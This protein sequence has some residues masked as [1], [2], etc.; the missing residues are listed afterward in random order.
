MA[1]HQDQNFLDETIN[2]EKQRRD[3]ADLAFGIDRTGGQFEEPQDE[4][5]FL[6]QLLAQLFGGNDPAAINQA[7]LQGMQTPQGAGA[8]APILDLE[9]S[10]NRLVR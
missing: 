10:Q 6:I 1:L 8:L 9:A 7:N 2:Q 3:G 5:S 4:E